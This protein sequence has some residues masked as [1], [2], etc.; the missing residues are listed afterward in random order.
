[1]KKALVLGILI[2]AFAVTGCSDSSV[3]QSNLLESDQSAISLKEYGR[4][5]NK[6]DIISGDYFKY[7]IMVDKDTGVEYII[8]EYDGKKIS[9]I[10]RY[11]SDGSLKINK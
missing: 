5:D 9:V 3:E 4:M 8:V 11:N 1:M 6:N 7:Y 2:G 10:P